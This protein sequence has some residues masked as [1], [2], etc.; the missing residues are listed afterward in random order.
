M[1]TDCN[2]PSRSPFLQT[3]EALIDAAGLTDSALRLLQAMVMLPP[4]N[5]R[6]SDAVAR[7]LRMGKVKTNAA[8]KLLREQGHWHGRKRQNVHGE[9]RDQRMA[10]LV[11]LKTREAVAAGWAAAEEAAR[12]GKDTA[13]SRRLGVRIVNAREWQREPAA[14][15]PD[16]RVTRRRSP[17]GDQTMGKQTPLPVP[18]AAAKPAPVPAPATATVPVTAKDGDGLDLPPLT[19]PLAQYA[20]EAERVLLRLRKAAPTPLV[21]AVADARELAHIAGHYLL[22]GETPE[23]IRA[24]LTS[25]LPAGGVHAPRGFARQ[26]LLRYLPPVPSWQRQRAMGPRGPRPAQAREP[27]RTGPDTPA[28]VAGGPA[29]L[30]TRGHGWR[31]VFAAT[32]QQEP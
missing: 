4:R 20:E 28:R 5:A 27:V 15:S 14:G 3:P 7:S 8:R 31:A 17:A 2:A 10:S 19:G 18:A 12:L 21:L 24:A 29:D 26:R 11:P 13:A 6:N 9:I 32:Q 30:I 1:H 22:R 16:R 25:G 23:T